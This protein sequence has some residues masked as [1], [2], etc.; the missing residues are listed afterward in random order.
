MVLPDFLIIVILQKPANIAIQISEFP[1]IPA[2]VSLKSYETRVILGGFSRSASLQI[3]QEPLISHLRNR[4]SSQLSVEIVAILKCRW[5]AWLIGSAGFQ[6]RL[7]RF[8]S[9]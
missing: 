3:L 2:S 9:R 5:R 8:A 1:W 4:F 6:K 7:Q